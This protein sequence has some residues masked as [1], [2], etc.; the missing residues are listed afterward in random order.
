[1]SIEGKGQKRKRNIL[2]RARA[3]FLDRD[4]TINEDNG[5]LSDVRNLKIIPGA[6]EAVNLLKE[7]GFLI[8]IV[9]NQ[10]GLA[11]GFFTVENLEQIHDQIK[12]IFSLDGI[13]FCPH[14]PDE[15]CSCRKPEPKMVLDVAEKFRI[16][17]GKSYVIG[18]TR[19]DLEMGQRAGCK[20]I[21]VLTGKGKE[22]EALLAGS[23]LPVEFIAKD[24]LEAA[25]WITQHSSKTRKS[26]VNTA[27][28]R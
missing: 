28:M 11:R 18:D 15:N 24:I 1:M 7:E 10:S 19:S 5:Y 3:V 2:S 20:S 14:H 12:K 23:N 4:G 9:T 8:F 25:K 17:R 27:A 16:G 6:V 13:S 26:S 21:L 22:T